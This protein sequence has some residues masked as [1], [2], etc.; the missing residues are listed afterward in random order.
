MYQEHDVVVLRRDLPDQGLVTDDVG[1][2]VGV[3]RTG[4]YEV[5]FMPQTATPSQWSR[6]PKATSGR[7]G[8]ARSSTS[9]KEGAA[10]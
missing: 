2:V 7:E 6:S 4:G 3:Y 10:L 5:E 9:A 1:A 8:A